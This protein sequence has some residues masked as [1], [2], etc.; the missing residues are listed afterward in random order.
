MGALAGG[1][2]AFDISLVFLA[3]S[4]FLTVYAERFAVLI[5]STVTE[6]ETI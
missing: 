6:K 5:C 3:M 1:S 4:G 2:C